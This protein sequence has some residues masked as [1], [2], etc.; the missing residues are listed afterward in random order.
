MSANTSPQKRIS[1]SEAV[2]ACAPAVARQLVAN[3]TL[4]GLHKV[5]IETFAAGLIQNY[6]G[7]SAPQKNTLGADN[8]GLCHLSIL[9]GATLQAADDLLTRKGLL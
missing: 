6:M 1:N 2:Y 8:P 7:P 5:E 9:V 4:L 3:R